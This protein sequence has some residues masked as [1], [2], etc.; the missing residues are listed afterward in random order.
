MVRVFLVTIGQVCSRT[1][2]WC[3]SYIKLLDFDTKPARWAPTPRFRLKNKCNA[4]LFFS[5]DKEGLIY[6]T[7]R[8]FYL[9]FFKNHQKILNLTY[10]FEAMQCL[11]FFKL[12]AR[13]ESLTLCKN[14]KSNRRWL[15]I[16]A[17]RHFVFLI[18]STSLSERR[19]IFCLDLETCEMLYLI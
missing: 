11:L 9:N 5:T 10:F 19:N 6:L 14:A 8:V 15:L 16:S 18:Q 12:F 3:F 7:K 1:E 2:F 4:L 17:I 13:K